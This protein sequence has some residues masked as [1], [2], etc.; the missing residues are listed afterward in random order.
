MD[1]QFSPNNNS[2]PREGSGLDP[3]QLAQLV[4]A[5][6]AARQVGQSESV[7]PIT[8]TNSRVGVGPSVDPQQLARL[9]RAA[10]ALQQGGQPA[11]PAGQLPT[12]V[13]TFSVLGPVDPFAAGAGAALGNRT[14]GPQA[15]TT[16]QPDPA[17]AAAIRSARQAQA[18]GRDGAGFGEQQQAPLPPGNPPTNN[19]LGGRNSQIADDLKRAADYLKWRDQNFRRATG[20]GWEASSGRLYTDEELHGLY[21]AQQLDAVR[22]QQGREQERHASAAGRGNTATITYPDGMK[23]TRTG[24]HPQRDNNPGDIEYRGSFAREHGAIGKDKASA[25]FPSAEA[26][27]AAMDALLKTRDYQAKTIDE[28]VEAYAPPRNRR[29]QVMNDTAKYQANVRAALGVRGDTKISLLSPEQFEMLKQT[30]AQ[31]EGYYDK[32]PNHKVK[33]TRELPNGRNL[34]PRN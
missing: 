15:S 33:V 34:I 18:S 20:G 19:F 8:S 30:I 13:P 27:W 10:R 32:R 22:A 5:A 25:I 17:K 7:S 14:A 24:N 2:G 11:G 1:G 28:A 12:Q 31:I 26:G 6:Q 29:G 23:E 16:P 21:S 3:Q 4:L 9:V